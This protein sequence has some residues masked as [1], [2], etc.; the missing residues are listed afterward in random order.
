MAACTWKNSLCHEVNVK[1]HKVKWTESFPPPHFPIQQRVEHPTTGKSLSFGWL[2]SEW[3][4]KWRIF[5]N[6]KVEWTSEIP[7]FLI[8]W[9][10]PRYNNFL[11]KTISPL[12]F[13]C[14]VGKKIQKEF[15][16]FPK[17]NERKLP[18]KNL[19]VILLHFNR[20]HWNTHDNNQKLFAFTAFEN[21]IKMIFQIFTFLFY[22]PFVETLDPICWLERELSTCP[23]RA[24]CDFCTLRDKNQLNFWFIV[25]YFQFWYL[26]VSSNYIRRSFLSW[27][28]KSLFRE[29]VF[30]AN[31]INILKQIKEK[32]LL[33]ESWLYSWIRHK[34]KYWNLK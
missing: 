1:I 11:C 23:T 10:L 21:D 8:P 25:G 5:P 33:R 31:F 9:S 15:P 2:N 26:D 16:P 17:I 4:V 3:L 6:L 19:F 20:L 22:F 14:F 12:C 29:W 27:Y 18:K 24:S 34:A 28:R 13:E 30:I 7:F 32:V